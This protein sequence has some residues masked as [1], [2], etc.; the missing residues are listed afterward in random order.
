MNYGLDCGEFLEIP[1]TQAKS[2]LAQ[3]S[4]DGH[5]PGLKGIVPDVVVQQVGLEPL[6]SLCGSVSPH[7]AVH[8]G[9]GI[10]FEESLEE[11]RSQEA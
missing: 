11:K 6:H 10:L 8:G 5:N 3:V 4:E 7:K 1:F 9:L 2:W